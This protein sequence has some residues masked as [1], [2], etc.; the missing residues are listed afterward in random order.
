MLAFNRS[1]LWKGYYW[2]P[3]HLFSDSLAFFKYLTLEETTT[4]P[5]YN[6]SPINHMI[7]SSVLPLHPHK[8]L[9][10]H[11]QGISHTTLLH[12]H[13]TTALSCPM[14]SGSSCTSK[15]QNYLES[16]QMHHHL[17]TPAK[18]YLPPAGPALF[19][20]VLTSCHNSEFVDLF[21]PT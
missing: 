19:V 18:V 4:H 6:L 12:L 11:F 21:H 3:T 7:S 9:F 1:P 10:P 5:S 13:H 16:H 14:C 8:C 20:T 15:V 2:L 17:W